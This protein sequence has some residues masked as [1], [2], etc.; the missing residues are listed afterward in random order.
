MHLK[1][2]Y[3]HV[4][5]LLKVYSMFRLV[6]YIQIGLRLQNEVHQNQS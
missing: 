3:S 4:S 5:K 6:K 2:C 1:L